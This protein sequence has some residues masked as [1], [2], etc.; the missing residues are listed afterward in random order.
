ME[1]LKAVGIRRG[2]LISKAAVNAIGA[3]LGGGR[4]GVK[5]DHKGLV[6]IFQPLSKIPEYGIRS[7]QRQG[8]YGQGWIGGAHAGK[9]PAAQQIK[10]L[11]IM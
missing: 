1:W 3:T 10:V 2:Q 9:D 7:H 8:R 4:A 11:V 6:M 5:S